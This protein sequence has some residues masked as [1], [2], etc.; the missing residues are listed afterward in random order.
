VVS[1]SC[2]SHAKELRQTICMRTA[3]ARNKEKGVL[4]GNRMGR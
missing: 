4:V 3:H 1:L 2:V